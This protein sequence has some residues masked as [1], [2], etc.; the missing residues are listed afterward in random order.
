MNNPRSRGPAALVAVEDAQGVRD[1]AA[2]SAQVG[3]HRADPRRCRP[4]M[5]NHSM[6]G[7]DATDPH[8]PAAFRAPALGHVAEPGYD[9]KPSAREGLI[10]AR[11]AELE[12]AGATRVREEESYGGQLGHVVML[13]PEGNEFCVS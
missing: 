10:R 7:C 12:V 8:R 11:V 4:T 9:G 2:A 3:G 5:A 1:D 6:L 13:D